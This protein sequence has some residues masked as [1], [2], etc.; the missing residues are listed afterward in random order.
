MQ[1]GPSLERWGA[2]LPTPQESYQEFSRALYLGRRNGGGT[3]SPVM[4]TAVPPDPQDLSAAAYA[5]QVTAAFN[6]VCKLVGPRFETVLLHFAIECRAADI[7]SLGD[8]RHVAA[9]APEREADHVGFH[10]FERTD[11]AVLSHRWNAKC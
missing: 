8:F 10:R 9:V 2:P 5:V 3:V 6:A 7:Q 1:P 4:P 11:F